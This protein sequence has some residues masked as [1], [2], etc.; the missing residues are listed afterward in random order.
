MRKA[1][2]TIRS[3]TE[4]CGITAHALPT[5]KI[6]NYRKIEQR[7]RINKPALSEPEVNCPLATASQPT[8][9]PTEGMRQ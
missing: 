1:G 3:M 9:T 5:H 7:I 2:Y 4:R 6:A 8:V